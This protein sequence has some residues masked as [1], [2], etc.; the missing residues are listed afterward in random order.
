MQAPVEVL[1]NAG[2]KFLGTDLWMAISLERLPVAI[3]LGP[4]PGFTP[5]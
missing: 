2:V 3:L 4:E 5:I 1:K